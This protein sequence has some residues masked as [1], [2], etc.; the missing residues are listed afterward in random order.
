MKDQ[1]LANFDTVVSHGTSSEALLRYLESYQ[2]KRVILIDATDIY[3]AGER[4]GRAFHFNRIASNS[5]SIH[6]LCLS[7]KHLPAAV[8]R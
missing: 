2:L 5:D 6:F 7:Q 4:H 3:T 1:N 8:A